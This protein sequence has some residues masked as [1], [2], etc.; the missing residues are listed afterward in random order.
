MVVCGAG[1]DGHA[2]DVGSFRFQRSE[3]STHSRQQAL[4][5]R[6]RLVQQ[7]SREQCRLLYSTDQ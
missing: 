6:H 2:D 1:M 5:S 3:R 7:V 4:A